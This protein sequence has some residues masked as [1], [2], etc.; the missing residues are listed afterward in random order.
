MVQGSYGDV[1]SWE[2][3]LSLVQSLVIGT[4]FNP[5]EGL[6]VLEIQDRTLQ[7]LGTCTDLLRGVETGTK[8][9]SV[10][11]A[12]TARNDTP[13]REAEALVMPAQAGLVIDDGTSPSESMVEVNTKAAY[14]QPQQFSLGYLR[15]LAAA[16]KDEAEDEIC[17]CPSEQSPALPLLVPEVGSQDP[18]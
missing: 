8:L 2:E 18:F 12:L 15:R 9:G 7:F 1:V 10:Q 16:K 4:G 11:A 17:M 3:D 6:I 5:S 14:R 13:N